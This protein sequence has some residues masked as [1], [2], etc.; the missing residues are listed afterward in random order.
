MTA[1][2]DD[3]DLV[4]IRI[5]KRAAAMYAAELDVA[6]APWLVRLTL[7]GK[8]VAGILAVALGATMGLVGTCRGLQ[9]D[10]DDVAFYGCAMT[11]CMG[12]GTLMFFI[13]KHQINAAARRGLL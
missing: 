7:Y 10:W 6:A 11:I 5:P 12:V 3:Q 13:G 9:S 4:T 1:H 2:D 8:Q